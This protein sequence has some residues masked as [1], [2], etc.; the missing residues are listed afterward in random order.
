MKRVLFGLE[1]AVSAVI[2]EF[3]TCAV[4]ELRPHPSYIRHRLTVSVAK[5]SALA[6]QGEEAF[7]E[8][9][10]ITQDGILL[11]GYARWE[12]ARHQER[13]SVTCIQYK[14][15]EDEALQHL[16]R[17]HGRSRGLNDFCRVL[18]ALEREPALKE[19]ARANQQAG[20]QRKGSSKLAE[21]QRL[22]VRREIARVAQVSMGNV[23]KV[24]EILSHAVPELLLAL[25]REEVR[26]HRAWQLCRL[27]PAQQR[28]AL[29]LYQSRRG[30]RTVIRSLISRHAPKNTPA[31][32]ENKDLIRLLRDV[33]CGMLDRVNVCVINAPGRTIFLTEELAKNLRAQK[34]MLFS[35]ATNSR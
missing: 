33:E 9:L 2:P 32:V 25:K 20:G 30:V 5:L 21:P 34:E 10:A 22:D 16:L 8:P 24:K 18:L 35:C 12:L 11:D 15:T 3:V 7:R 1:V 27:S 19:A 26:I 6:E 23:S 13:S 17:M 14:L 28:Q 4:S 31:P 29:E